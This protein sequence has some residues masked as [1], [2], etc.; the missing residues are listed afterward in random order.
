MR[1]ARFG[2]RK[3]LIVH[4]G[5]TGEITPSL[6]P[7]CFE[8]SKGALVFWVIRALAEIIPGGLVKG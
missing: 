6:L 5:Q 7:L 1:K 8:H 2:K 4:H 3:Y